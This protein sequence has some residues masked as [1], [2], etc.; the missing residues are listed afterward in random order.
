MPEE[1]INIVILKENGT[2]EEIQLDMDKDKNELGVYLQ[3]KLT[4]IGQ[5]IREETEENKTNIILIKGLNA[6]KNGKKINK[7]KLPTPFNEEQIFGDIILLPMN[8][9]IEPENIYIK[10]Y[11]GLFREI[12]S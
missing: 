7:C 3:D 8:D 1:I 9:K 6:E 5:I 2:I 4:F 11:Y 10:D 12:K